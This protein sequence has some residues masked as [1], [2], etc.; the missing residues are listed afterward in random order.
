MPASNSLLVERPS[1]VVAVFRLNRPQVRIAIDLEVRVRLA[2]E[3][4]RC[5]IALAPDT[6]RARLDQ[7]GAQRSRQASNISTS[8]SRYCQLRC[9]LRCS[10][11]CRRTQAASNKPGLAQALFRQQRFRPVPQRS[12]QPFAE[13]NAEA[14]LRALDQFRRHMAIEHLP[15]QPL[16]LAAAYFRRLRQRA[17]QIRPPG[18]RAAARAPPAPPPCWRD[19][20]WSGC[21]QAGRSR[22][23]AIACDRAARA[24][25][26]RAKD[27]RECLSA[28]TF[29]A[30]PH[31]APN[32]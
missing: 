3:K 6:T 16:A 21:R 31:S 17:K 14:H 5:L 10:A 15:Q 11:Q 13:R 19:R 1:D 28:P 23:R 26:P 20:P 4:I 22:G 25:P 2:N 32:G 27:P 29:R 24:F 8:H 12:A 18:D 9:P 30:S 7:P